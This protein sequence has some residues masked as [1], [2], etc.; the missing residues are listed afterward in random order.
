MTPRGKALLIEYAVRDDDEQATEAAPAPEII[1]LKKQRDELLEALQ[2]MLVWFNYH[3]V[4]GVNYGRSLA[5]TK[6]REAIAKAGG[7]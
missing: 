5:I 2:G 6:A 4:T 3:T 7:E 1:A